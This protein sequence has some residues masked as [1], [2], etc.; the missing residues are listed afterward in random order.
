MIMSEEKTYSLLDAHKHF[1]ISTNGL[2][3]KLLEKKDRSK[4]DE[5]LMIHAAHTSCYH[6]LQVGTGLHHQRA[7]WLLSHVYAELGIASAALKH[8]KRCLELTEDHV[9]LM[10][11]FDIAYSHE[12]LARANALSDNLQEAIMYHH[13]AEASGQ[14]IADEED[15]KIFLADFNGGNWYGL[16]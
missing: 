7:E 16:K 4:N 11:D 2:V 13:N 8:A 1:A 6:W 3:W 15:R 10:Q 14:A 12:A 9:E 5:E